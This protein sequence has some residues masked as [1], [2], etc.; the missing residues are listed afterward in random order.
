MSRLVKRQNLAADQ[1]KRANLVICT[2]LV[3]CY[4]AYIVVELININKFGLSGGLITRCILY[5]F[6]SLICITT[7]RLF[8]TNKR[9]EIIL[10]ITFLIGYSTLVFSNG[11]VVMMLV[12]PVLIGFMIY[13]NSAIVGLGCFFSLIVCITKCLIV[14]S[15]GNKELFN[16]GILILAG[17][18]VSIFASYITILL[19]ID[20]SKE[21]RA[22][23]ENEA[24][25]RAEVANTVERIAEKLD[26]DFKE[27]LQILKDV[28][29]SMVASGSAMDDIVSSSDSIATAIN[30]QADMTSHIQE[31]LENVTLRSQNVTKTTNELNDIVAQGKTIADK[32]KEQSDIVDNSI[33]KISDTIEQ[34]VANVER[35]SGI[36]QA[37]ENVS[38]QTNLLALNASIEAARAGEAGKGFAVVADEIQ[39][40]AEETR[41]SAEQ[42]DDIILKLNNVTTDTQSEIQQSA[43]RITEQRTQIHNVTSSFALA[44]SGTK[45]LHTNVNHMNSD[46]NSILEANKEIVNSITVLSAG[47]QEVTAGTHICKETIDFASS[48][49]SDFS[50]KVDGAFVELQQLENVVKS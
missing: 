27:I 38:T 10:A 19:L 4:F 11:V 33:R 47:T 32:L 41:I 16:Y 1:Y 14:L 17:L 45:Q 46:I 22:I 29:N 8:P 35:V 7:Y 26:V 50:K 2:I 5:A 43:E 13:L 36:T 48:K 42:I 49:L 6:L 18:I 24:A 40:L 9:C 23:I 15:D 3:L 30:H 28:D 21:D 20:F 39:K 12:F 44:E 34:L 31:R 25:H 37:I